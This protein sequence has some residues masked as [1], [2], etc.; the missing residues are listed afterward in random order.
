MTST[1]VLLVGLSVAQPGAGSVSG[2]DI[3]RLAQRVLRLDPGSVPPADPKDADAIKKLLENH[4]DLKRAV[5]QQVKDFEKLPP[6]KQ[7]EKLAELQKQTTD[8][9]IQKQLD[10]IFEKP[11]AATPTPPVA[12]PP[13][14]AD[15]PSPALPPPADSR[16]P[17]AQPGGS[18]QVPTPQPAATPPPPPPSPAPAP[19]TPPA[20]AGRAGYDKFVR[21][22]EQNVGPLKDMPAVQQLAKELLRGTADA[23][24]AGTSNGPLGDLLGSKAAGDLLKG[25]PEGG[26]RSDWKLPEF[27]GLPDAPGT[28]SLPKAS[29]APPSASVV[30]IGLG[31]VVAAVV[32]AVALRYL[33]KWATA[34]GPRPVPGLGPWP[35]DPRRVETRA[36]LVRAFEYLSVLLNGDRARSYSHEAAAAALREVVPDAA[37]AAGPLAD[38]Y[39]LARYTPTD[40]PLSVE[41]IADA[42]RHLCRLAGVP[43]A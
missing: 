41:Q 6:E 1:L 17:S 36:D 10:Q 32:L 12:P 18:D 25:L 38:A 20:A 31:L 3:K 26:D 9:A 33:P 34:D 39:A 8:P 27:G 40:Q 14:R 13:G 16:P 22:F 29:L 23:A 30:G 42:R 4:P 7:R 2:A 21:F 28:S 35:L 5:E 43:A 37:D 24:A 15:P 19:T 11:P